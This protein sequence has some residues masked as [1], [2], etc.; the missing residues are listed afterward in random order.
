MLAFLPVLALLLYLRQYQAEDHR[1]LS[2]ERT[3]HE[4]GMD[5]DVADTAPRKPSKVS[6]RP[7]HREP[8]TTIPLARPVRDQPGFVYHPVSGEIV[9]VRGIPAGHMVQRSG[10]MFLI[11]KMG[12][13]ITAEDYKKAVWNFGGETTVVS[14]KAVHWETQ[15]DDGT[16]YLPEKTGEDFPAIGQ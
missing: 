9:D 16:P 8:E 11:P 4:D 12:Y 15:W 1:S 14:C 10:T 7:E 6:Q 3:G 2:T 13:I 5:G